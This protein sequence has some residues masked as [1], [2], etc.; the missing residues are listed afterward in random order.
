VGMPACEQ[1]KTCPCAAVWP[2]LWVVCVT[3]VRLLELAAGLK[4]T[5]RSRVTTPAQGD[6]S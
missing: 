3:S 4:T 1:G 6:S 2:E 5:Q